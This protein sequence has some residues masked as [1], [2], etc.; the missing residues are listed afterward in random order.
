MRRKEKGRIVALD[1]EGG[2]V[3]KWWVAGVRRSREQTECKERGQKKIPG[4]F[5]LLAIGLHTPK[6][7]RKK[8]GSEQ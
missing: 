2:R 7:A 8:N 5:K 6:R 4:K 3:G 1:A